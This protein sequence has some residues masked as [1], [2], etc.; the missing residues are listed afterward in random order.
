MFRAYCGLIRKEF[1]QIL[2]DRIMLRVTFAMPIIQLLL[3][4]YAVNTDVRNIALDVYDYDR[5]R[6]SREL[7]Q[8]A[9]A[10]DY[11]TVNRDAPWRA[12]TPLWLREARF[13]HGTADM[14]LTIPPNF[15]ERLAKGDTVTVGL[16][17]DGADANAARI[18]SAYMQQIVGRYSARVVGRSSPL[19]TRYKFLYN[20]ELESVY[21][22]VPGIVAA[23]LTMVTVLLTAMAI[24]REREMGTLEQLMVTPMSAS[25]LLMGK[26]TTFAVLGFFEM[27]IAL[28]VG[29]LWF[30]IPFVGSPILLF[31]L[32]ALYLLTTLGLGM[33]FSTVT[34]TQQ[35]AMF[36]A[37]FF[38]VF[39]LLTSGFFTPISNMPT[40]VQ[41]VTYLNPMRYFMTIV[42]GVMMKG[43]GVRELLPN[44]Y[45]L[46]IYGVLTF[47]FSVMR[48]TK[49]AA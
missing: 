14:A 38:S 5:S 9:E 27:C 10:S 4:G 41:Y 33:F 39:A 44:I 13:E 20:A 26:I 23:L 17:A 48:F 31:A 11:F 28:A 19:E 30:R 25:T 45:P 1:I 8:A 43:A 6:Y 12:S 24:V 7:I 18:G 34:S 40:L 49:R 42:R 21:Y 35:Q 3:L 22:M 37:W 29:V 46:V 15:G 47:T 32:A 36:L 16:A 2:R